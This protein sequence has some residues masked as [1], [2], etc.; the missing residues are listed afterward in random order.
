RL[1][2]QRSGR[3]YKSVLSPQCSPTWVCRW[4]RY[5]SPHRPPRL[6][7]ASAVGWHSA[8]ARIVLMAR[9][10]EERAEM[11]SNRIV[12]LAS[13]IALGIVWA[14]LGLGAAVL[15]AVLGAAGWF[16]SGVATGE[17]DLVNVWADLRGR[18]EV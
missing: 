14:W 5:E 6:T 11:Q 18:S 9:R 17:V 2:L 13:G 12:G 7:G 4:R 16:I 3:N 10:G 1:R 15:A 8:A